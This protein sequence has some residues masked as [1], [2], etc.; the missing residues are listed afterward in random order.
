MKSISRAVGRDE[1]T[2]RK[3]LFSFRGDGACKG[4]KRKPLIVRATKLADIATETH[5]P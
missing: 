1:S 2:V 4:E 3:H 5:K